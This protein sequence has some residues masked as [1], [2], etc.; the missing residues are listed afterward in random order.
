MYTTPADQPQLVL[1][2]S[3]AFEDHLL[4]A[5]VWQAANDKPRKVGWIAY[6]LEHRLTSISVMMPKPSRLRVSV[7]RRTAS[8]NPSGSTPQYRKLVGAIGL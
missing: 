7:T 4:R 3:G 8:S 1:V 6:A 5:R 2:S